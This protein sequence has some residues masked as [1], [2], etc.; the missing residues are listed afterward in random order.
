MVRRGDNKAA[1]RRRQER[2]KQRRQASA[3]R[4]PGPEAFGLKMPTPAAP[5]GPAPRPDFS[6]ADWDKLKAAYPDDAHRLMRAMFIALIGDRARQ[7][8]EFLTWG[9]RPNLIHRESRLARDDSSVTLEGE[10]NLVSST[11]LYPVMNACEHLVAAAEVIALALTQGQIRTSATAALCRIAMESSAK[12]IWLISETDTEERIRRCYGFLKAERGRQEEFEKL[13][14]EALAARTDPLAEADR[15][16]FD[17]RRARVAARQ[18]KVAALPAGAITGPSGG[19]LKLVERAEAWMDEYLPRKADPELD[20]VMHPRSAKS[21]Y[22]LGS[23]FVH[24]FKWLMGYVLDDRVLDD[25]PLLAITLDAFG[26]AIRMTE[27]AVSLY[28]AQSI[29]PR[30]DPR[31]VRNYPAGLADAVASLAPHYR[32]AENPL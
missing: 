12:T 30:P 8:K 18:D 3:D 29:G 21:F 28:E 1:K 6:E 17:K 14:D 25:S 11:A 9:L 5:G 7:A 4:E 13:E 23:G 20:A 16:D 15:A 26:N 27:A 10:P 19:P 22:S 2:E 31:R 24:G 32:P